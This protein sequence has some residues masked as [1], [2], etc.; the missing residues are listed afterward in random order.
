MELVALFLATAIAAAGWYLAT[1]GPLDDLAFLWLF[2]S[3]FGS[4]SLYF[5][6]FASGRQS[7]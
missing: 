2:S 3:W 4:F 5:G 6:L 7:V 1:S